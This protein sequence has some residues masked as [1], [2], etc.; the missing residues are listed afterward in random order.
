[1]S[2]DLIYI[3]EIL[4]ALLKAMLVTLRIAISGYLLAFI[5]GLLIAMIRVSGNVFLSRL[6]LMFTEFIRLTPILVQLFFFY[7]VLPEV[8]IKLP[9]EPTGIIV[10]GLHYSTFTAE[11]FRS[12]ILAIPK[13]QWEVSNTLCLPFYIKWFKIILP[14]SI[15]PMI[16]ALGNYLIQLFKEVPLLSTITVYELLNTANLIA[17]ETFRYFEVL[18]IVAILFFLIS[19]PSAIFFR[20]L[21]SKN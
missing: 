13:G 16:P 21:E 18:S 14:Q 1:M 10:L 20:N 15:R 2:I 3:I 8:G 4:P 19:Y 12:G 11:V 5:L 17:G 9:A 6:L 7:Y